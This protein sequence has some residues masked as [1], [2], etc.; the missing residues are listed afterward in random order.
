MD[1][2]SFIKPR[3]GN[4]VDWSEAYA[5]VENYFCSLRIQNKLLL[6]QLVAKILTRAAQRLE[7]SPGMSPQ[8]LAME[9]ARKEVLE[10][11]ESV[12]AAANVTSD[13]S[14]AKGRLALFLADMPVRWQKEFL[15][16]GPWPDDFLDAFRIT[17]LKTGPD[18]QKGVMRPREIDLGPVSAI[19]DETWK[20]I[21][22]W[23][24]LGTTLVWS[25]Y[26]GLLGVFFY[27]TR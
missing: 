2:L 12:M 20:A 16:P 4:Y 10:W 21:D 22:R 27:L 17:Y 11:F 14:G 1:P 26:L 3:S 5:R 23:P 7:Q 15:H 18:F 19:A 8:K 13:E 25:M 9:E 6:S 24:L